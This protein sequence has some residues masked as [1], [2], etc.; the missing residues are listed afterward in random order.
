[1]V[2]V[3]DGTTA[4]D[5]YQRHKELARR[6]QAILSMEGRD[7]YPIPKCK[8]HLLRESVSKSFRRFCEVVFTKSFYLEWS[9]DHLE[10]ID[11]IEK[12]VRY[13]DLFAI[14][15][16]RGSGKTTIGIA[17]VIW[18]T[19]CGYRR[20][21]V[22]IGANRNKASKLLQSI[23]TIFQTN[24][25]L[26]DL[27]P[28]VCYPIKRLE[29]KGN[30]A[31]GQ[32]YQGRQTHIQWTGKSITFAGIS[33]ICKQSTIE[34]AGLQGEVRG[35][36]FVSTDGE[37]IRPDFFILDDPQTDQTASNKN[38]NEKR[39]ALI[40]GSVL[41]LAGPDKT[42]TGFALVTVIKPDDMADQLLDHK[43]FPTWQGKRGKMVY[44]WPKSELWEKYADL[45]R[46]SKALGK[47]YQLA[48][49]FYKKNR[50]EMD[51]GA[52]VGWVQRFR[53]ELGE[54]SAIQCAWNHRIEYKEQFWPEFQN[55]PNE[56]FSE[57]EIISQSDLEEKTNGFDRG[58]IPHEADILTSFIDVQGKLLYW[59]V[60]A[61]RSSDFTGWIVDYGAWPEQPSKYYTL[62]KASRTLSDKYKGT[63]LE[64]R[65]RAGLFDLID[66]LG[67][68]KFT[69]LAGNI[70]PM[71]A[72]GID[73][74]WGEVTSTIQS[75]ALEHPF[76]ANIMPC[77]GRGLRAKDKPI[78][79]WGTKPGETKGDNWIVRKNEHG[80]RHMIIET[81][82]WKSFMHSRLNIA[83]GDKG[84][85]SLFRPKSR[86]EHKMIA[87][88]I[89]AENPKNDEANGRKM[90]IFELKSNK[91][92]NHLGDGVSNCAALASACG[93]K[94]QEVR[95]S[96][97]LV[98][99]RS[100]APRR[101]TS[102]KI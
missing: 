8:N 79:A 40:N 32:T 2:N 93:A 77:F 53:K 5:S 64:G 17:A 58:V 73:A 28:E 44:Q 82:Y 1:M 95:Q 25:T 84:S 7:I 83:I 98:E 20:Y 11:R 42:I 54:L 56:E 12:S 15:M 41:G 78:A 33:G 45:V 80:G 71:K 94:L 69:S 4:N 43:K 3:A 47:G 63:G 81:N 86:T 18:A 50:V 92:D 13:G 37:V 66:M 96:A 101:K 52:V 67:N 48:T 97:R 39:L 60:T 68:R 6:R 74:A 31:I 38:Q 21:V 9:N 49:E 55:E 59:V 100:P 51:S 75:V 30:K 16:P 76:T 34:V 22:L 24:E 23:K 72:I 36:Q 87:E 29:G 27:F 61:W 46:E 70:L 88:H 19:I 65:I 62:S 57:V 99:R 89:L 35:G 14:A 91:P 90:T 102:I 26:A 10:I 85:L